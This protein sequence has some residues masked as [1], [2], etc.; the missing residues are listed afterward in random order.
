MSHRAL[1]TAV[2][3][4]LITII[5]SV[6]PPEHTARVCFM[7]ALRCLCTR[8]LQRHKDANCAASIERLRRVHD[9]GLLSRGGNGRFLATTMRIQQRQHICRDPRWSATG[10]ETNRSVWWTPMFP[11]QKD[12]TVKN[13]LHFL[14]FLFFFSNRL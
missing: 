5:R 9:K 2:Y 3:A 8:L 7:L 11:R 14:Y 1:P 10:A 6:M 12:V 4:G 13:M